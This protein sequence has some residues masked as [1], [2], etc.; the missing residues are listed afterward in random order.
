M[1]FMRQTELIN[2]SG[3]SIG[4]RLDQL[5]VEELDLLDFGVIGFD[6]E[7][8]VCRYNR[9]ESRFAD[10]RP[11]RVIG[12][13]LFTVVAPCMNNALI[14]AQFEQALADNT[15]MDCELN[16]VLTLRMRPVRVRLRLV[17]APELQLRYVLVQR[18]SPDQI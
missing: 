8:I 10:L 2:F 14:A 6:R 15:S 9:F 11:E 3:I 13:P 5:A 18:A 1:L 12:R 16:Y 7:G 4:R 17:A